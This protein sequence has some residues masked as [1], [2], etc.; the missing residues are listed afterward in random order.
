MIIGDWKALATVGDFDPNL[1]ALGVRVSQRVSAF[2]II[3]PNICR[4]LTRYPADNGR[5][6]SVRARPSCLLFGPELERRSTVPIS[7]RPAS[8]GPRLP[9]HKT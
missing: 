7:I 9:A 1:P 2:G 4:H 3:R 8:Q 5:S 6:I